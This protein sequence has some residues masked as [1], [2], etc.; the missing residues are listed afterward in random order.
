MEAAESV[1]ALDALCIAE[2]EAESVATLELV[3]EL[4]LVCVSVGDSVTGGA[5]TVAVADGLAVG[6]GA[7]LC[8][9]SAL[10]LSLMLEAGVALSEGVADTVG[11]PAPVTELLP[12]LS[13]VAVGC[14]LCVPPLLSVAGMVAG[15]EAVALPLP[16]EDAVA[17]TLLVDEAVA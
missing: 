8:E 4:E 13:A 16:V 11:D 14:E 10:P 6:V 2:D 7:L 9:G 17:L 3:P 12:V 1:L 5:V 15:D